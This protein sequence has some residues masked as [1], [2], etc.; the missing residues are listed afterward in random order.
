VWAVDV[1]PAMLKMLPVLGRGAGTGR[2]FIL[3][4]G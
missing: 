4:P 3:I 1:Q 2:R